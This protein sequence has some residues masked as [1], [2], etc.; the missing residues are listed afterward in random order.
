MSYYPPT[1]WMLKDFYRENAETLFRCCSFL[2]CG[3][4]DAQKMVRDIFM[5]ML[6]KGISFSSDKD[7]KAWMMLT[8]YKMS[9][10][11][12]AAAAVP[13]NEPVDPAA[14]SEVVTS[15]HPDAEQAADALR[16]ADVQDEHDTVASG[17]RSAEFP[18]EL[19]D[20]SRKDRLIAAFYY[21]EGFRKAEIAKYLGWTTFM[22]SHRLRRIR[23]KILQEKGGE[24]AC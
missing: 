12:P 17:E 24:E 20:L 6:S 21:C 8:A 22:V 7:A 13:G 2:T 1:D 15:D 19:R 18:P 4:A 5:H 16:A 9:K 23:K 10:K 11:P 3:Q 14:N